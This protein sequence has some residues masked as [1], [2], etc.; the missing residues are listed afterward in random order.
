MERI[1]YATQDLDELEKLVNLIIKN[2]FD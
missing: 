1:Y 2:E